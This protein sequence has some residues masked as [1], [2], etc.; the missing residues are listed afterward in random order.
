L[1]V[2]EV[3]VVMVVEAVLADLEQ[4]QVLLLL[5]ATHTQLQLVLVVAEVHLKVFKA[6]VDQTLH[7]IL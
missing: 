3:G 1:L 7:L 4:E 6:L 5:L 2:V